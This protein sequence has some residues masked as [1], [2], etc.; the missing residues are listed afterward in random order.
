MKLIVNGQEQD[1]KAASVLEL[2]DHFV[3]KPKQVVVELNKVIIKR[4]AF[5]HQ[6]VKE[7]D[8]IEIVT[9]VGGG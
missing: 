6:S 3:L 8:Q 5:A 1:I 9:V 4:E 7:N 2:L